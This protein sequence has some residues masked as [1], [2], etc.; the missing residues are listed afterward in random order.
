MTHEFKVGQWVEYDGGVYQIYHM[1]H[2]DPSESWIHNWKEGERN[3]I[4]SVHTASLTPLTLRDGDFVKTEGMTQ[5][6]LSQ[7]AGLAHMTISRIECGS[8]RPSMDALR[9]IAVALGVTLDDLA[10]EE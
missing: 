10:G 7:R 2:R 9:K 8:P 4:G 1:D 5:E 3:N 6:Q